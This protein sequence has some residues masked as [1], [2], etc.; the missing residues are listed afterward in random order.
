[1]VEAYDFFLYVV[2]PAC[3]QWSTPCGVGV[4]DCEP[5]YPQREHGVSPSRGTNARHRAQR[6]HSHSPIS[7]WHCEQYFALVMY[8]VSPPPERGA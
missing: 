5:S 8:D 2:G 7:S 4:S 3:A 1:M 6:G